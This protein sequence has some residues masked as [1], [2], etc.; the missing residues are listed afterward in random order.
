MYKYTHQV[1]LALFTRLVHLRHFGEM[2]FLGEAI[3]QFE[4]ANCIFGESQVVIH[5]NEP[6]LPKVIC[7]V[8]EGID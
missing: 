7:A 8:V 2:T 1:T 5:N 6:T 3:I 4:R